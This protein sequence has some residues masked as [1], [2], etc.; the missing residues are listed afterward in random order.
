M[1]G[2]LFLALVAVVLFCTG[3]AHA[4][5]PVALGGGSGIVFGDGS[6]CTLTTIGR[7]GQ[8]RLVGFTAAHCNTEGATVSAEADP[9]AGV[10]GTLVSRDTSLDYAVIEFAPEL[11]TPVNT[12]GATTITEV[13]RPAEF[14]A[15][16][17]KQGRTTGQTCGLV[18]GDVFATDTWTL[19][20]ICVLVGDSG[21]PVVVG[22]T[23]VALVNGYL[24]VPCLGPQV[25]IDFSRVLAEVDAGGGVGA[26]FR[27]V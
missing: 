2:R 13:G 16:A 10:L 20:Q 15:V 12:V 9:D 19:T 1:F 17:C 3:N 8:G 27:P 26:G 24:S 4:A 7:D 5:A 14:P 18:Y 6:I 25:G 22:T 11:V 23:L 21:G